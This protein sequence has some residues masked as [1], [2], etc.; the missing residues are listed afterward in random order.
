MRF[1]I[2][3]SSGSKLPDHTVFKDPMSWKE[4]MREELLDVLAIQLRYVS[5]QREVLDERLQNI[6]S[7]IF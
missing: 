1:I 4:I 6:V 7:R 3:D 2:L 5:L